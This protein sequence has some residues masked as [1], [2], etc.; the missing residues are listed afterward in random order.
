MKEF[1]R[2][3]SEEKI[4]LLGHIKAVKITLIIFVLP[5]SGYLFFYQDIEMVIIWSFF[6]GVIGGIILFVIGTEIKNVHKDIQN[7]NVEMII[8]KITKGCSHFSLFSYK[9]EVDG[10][11]VK[12]E[13]NFIH[14]FKLGQNLEIV[15]APIS[16]L[17]LNVKS[18]ERE[19]YRL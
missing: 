11:K 7:G 13:Y 18:D 2:M 4:Q 5:F 17:T 10:Q 16:K 6:F 3:K 12:I 15:K 9:M 8:G 1:R 19:I 14:D